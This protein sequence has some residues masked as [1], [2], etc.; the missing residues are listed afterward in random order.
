LTKEEFSSP[1]NGI[2]TS[3]AIDNISYKFEGSHTGYSIY[4]KI[5]LNENVTNITRSMK[6]VDH[7]PLGMEDEKVKAME[8]I[9][10]LNIPQSQIFIQEGKSSWT[11]S[12]T[13]YWFVP[14]DKNNILYMT[15]SGI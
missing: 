14:K 1:V 10:K 11:S 3:D 6:K 5:T 4:A 12:F 7:I 8:N 15:G 13:H 2:V 9:W